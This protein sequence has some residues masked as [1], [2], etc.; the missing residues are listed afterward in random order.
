MLIYS[1]CV[2][3]YIESVLQSLPPSNSRTFSLPPKEA[4]PLV[5][6]PNALATTHVFSILMNWPLWHLIQ[7]ALC[8]V[9]PHGVGVLLVWCPQNSSLVIL[10]SL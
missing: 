6:P 7:M 2:R 1:I 4:C 3:S 10:D 9:C 8:S 5:Y